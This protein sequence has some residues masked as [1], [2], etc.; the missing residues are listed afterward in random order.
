MFIPLVLKRNDSRIIEHDKNNVDCDVDY[1]T[2]NL[3]RLKINERVVNRVVKN[4]RLMANNY[5]AAASGIV[6]FYSSMSPV[7]RSEFFS[8]LY[9]FI[10]QFYS[11]D[12]D[13]KKVKNPLSLFKLFTK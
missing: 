7:F 10:K 12:E 2:R 3:K 11:K 6:K 1:I 13:F 5:C 8:G 9:K 4:Y